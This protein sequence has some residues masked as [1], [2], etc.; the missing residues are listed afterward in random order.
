MSQ[1]IFNLITILLNR[2]YDEFCTVF[3]IYLFDSFHEGCLKGGNCHFS[4]KLFTLPLYMY[5][6]TSMTYTFSEQ[7]V[8]SNHTDFWP[9]IMSMANLI[10]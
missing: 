6:E 10:Y 2:Q 7:Q 4:E 1:L 5:G 3:D 8:S 9:S